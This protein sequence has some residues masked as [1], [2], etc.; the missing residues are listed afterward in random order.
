MTNTTCL[1]VAREYKRL[2]AELAEMTAQCNEMRQ[3]IMAYMA[4]TGKT[5][6][7]SEEITVVLAHRSRSQ[8][9]T[10]ALR[11]DH[12]DIV[13]NYEYVTEYNELKIL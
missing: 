2:K 7:A 3:E 9:D 4:M 8:L 6:I 1:D 5:R 11:T 12:P 10:K 13:Q